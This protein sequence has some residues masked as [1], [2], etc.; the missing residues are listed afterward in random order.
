MED[1]NVKEQQKKGRSVILKLSALFVFA[2]LV[3]ALIL[4]H[5]NKKKARFSFD[6]IE[7]AYFLQFNFGLSNPDEYKFK[8]L[9]IY[10][11]EDSNISERVHFFVNAK[12]DEYYDMPEFDLVGWKE[13]D[14]VA[15]GENGKLYGSYCLNWESTELLGFED[16]IKWFNKA[17][18]E[19]KHKSYSQEEI[20][21]LIEE[22]PYVIEE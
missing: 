10:C 13:I 12:Y 14:E 2:T 17:V 20:Q 16:E 5:Q 1:E 21:K 15:Y 11:I 7:K 8:S 6:E 19:G 22:N 3:V 9:D 18:K 4:I